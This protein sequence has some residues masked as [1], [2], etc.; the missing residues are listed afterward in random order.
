MK[1]K[2]DPL[3]FFSRPVLDR[4]SLPTENHWP[5]QSSK[6]EQFRQEARLLQVPELQQRLS[7]AKKH[8]ES[9]E[10]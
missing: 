10:E 5:T 8:E 4:V 6:I 2:Y 3:F 9:L 1:I 7:L